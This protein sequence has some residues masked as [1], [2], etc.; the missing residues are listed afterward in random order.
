VIVDPLN[1]FKGF[2]SRI[3][4]LLQRINYVYGWY[5]STRSCKNV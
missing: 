2:F 5:G 3:I 4:F 1:G